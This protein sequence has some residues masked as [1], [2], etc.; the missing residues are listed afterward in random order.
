MEQIRLICAH[1]DVPIETFIHG[2]MCVNYSGRCTLSNAMTAR[3]ANRG[4]RGSILPLAL[5]SLSGIREAERRFVVVLNG[6]EGFDGGRLCQSDD[7]SRRGQPE[8]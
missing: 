6:I 8:N 7:G 3:D 5:S 2:G 4:G 1:S